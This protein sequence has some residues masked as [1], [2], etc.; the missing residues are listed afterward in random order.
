M[1]PAPI[2]ASSSE[3]C[4]YRCPYYMDG[5]VLS[6]CKLDGKQLRYD[7]IP[8]LRNELCKATHQPAGDRHE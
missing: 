7:G 5:S 3:R 1:K 4:S 8:P 6:L 2:I